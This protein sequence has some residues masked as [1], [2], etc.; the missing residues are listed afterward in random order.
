[1]EPVILTI[2]ERMGPEG[3][4]GELMLMPDLSI[5]QIEKST[6]FQ[7]YAHMHQSSWLCFWSDG[8][9]V[10]LTQNGTSIDI[11]GCRAKFKLSLKNLFDMLRRRFVLERDGEVVAEYSTRLDAAVLYDPTYD[12]IDFDSDNFFAWVQTILA[13]NDS[14]DFLTAQKPFKVPSS[15]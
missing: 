7:G 11:T 13:G 2:F 12:G 10:Y 1:M 8:K 15:A 6:E 9:S 14:V 5:Q 4:H 3:R